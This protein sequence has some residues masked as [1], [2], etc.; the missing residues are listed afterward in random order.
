MSLVGFPKGQQRFTPS[1][2]VT[3]GGFPLKVN[4]Q[5]YGRNIHLF[6]DFWK[7]GLRIVYLT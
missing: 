3:F 7:R 4:R 2:R 1:A 6:L 5:S